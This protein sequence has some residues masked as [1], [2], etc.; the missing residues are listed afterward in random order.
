MIE[1]NHQ[2]EI[3]KQWVIKFT[4]AVTNVE[5]GD[6]SVTM[7]DILKRGLQSQLDDLLIEIKEYENS[8]ID[9]II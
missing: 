9:I 2:C 3:T 4:E 7:K 5:N 8:K 6:L 1:N